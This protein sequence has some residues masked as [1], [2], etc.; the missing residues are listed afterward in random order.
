MTQEWDW[1]SLEVLGGTAWPSS[2]TPRYLERLVAGGPEES[3][4]A[5]AV[6]YCEVANQ[7]QLYTAAAPCVDFITGHVR[8]GG[9]P[10]TA[11]L[12]LLE[13]ILNARDPGSTVVVDGRTV[14]TAAYCRARIL[15]IVP[16]ILRTANP[17]DPDHFRGVCFLVPQ[18][19]DSAPQILDFLRGHAFGRFVG[20]RKPA[21]E[22]LE[23]AEEVVRDGHSP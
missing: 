19:A 8:A 12:S 18:L 11:A 9:R 6:L 13:E 15:E 10:N 23:E 22:A 7:G 21:L 3:H 2:R 20:A 14:D 4:R 5:R 1:S 17:A 16:E